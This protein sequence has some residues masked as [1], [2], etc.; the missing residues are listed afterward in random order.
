[1]A[2]FVSMNSPLPS[3]LEHLDACALRALLLEREQQL[4]QTRQSL[5]DRENALAQRK[6]P[7]N[8]P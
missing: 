7:A 3:N 8:T 1:M 2:N 6:I 4:V 5:A